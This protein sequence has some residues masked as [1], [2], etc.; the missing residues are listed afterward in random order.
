MPHTEQNENNGSIDWDFKITLH[1]AHISQNEMSDQIELK[2]FQILNDCLS[3][4]LTKR[5][6]FSLQ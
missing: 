4:G 3:Q 2:S 1:F 6:Y 5:F